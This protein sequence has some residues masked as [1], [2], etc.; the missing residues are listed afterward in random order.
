MNHEGII[1]EIGMQRFGW[2]PQVA[3]RTLEGTAFI[4][5]NSRMVSLNPVGTFIWDSFRDGA[6]V[7]EVTLA[8]TEEFAVDA[9]SASADTVGFVEMLVARELLAINA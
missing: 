9:E 7:S 5:H 8:V 6:T 3:S 4:L 1:G 2:H